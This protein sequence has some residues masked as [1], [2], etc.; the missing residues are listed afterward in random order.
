MTNFS[1]CPFTL[2]LITLTF[3]LQAFQA[4]SN[5]ATIINVCNKT[6]DPTLCKTCLHSDPKSKTADVRGLA[7]ISITCGTRDANKL[8]TDTNDLDKG[9]DPAK[10]A[11]TRDVIPF[12]DFCSD[13]FKKNPKVVVPHKILDEMTVVSKDCRIILGILSNISR[14]IHGE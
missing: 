7:S 11:I 4:T 5:E 3:T 1:L 10:L 6:P 2:S 12:I 8:Y 13:L 14:V 9:S